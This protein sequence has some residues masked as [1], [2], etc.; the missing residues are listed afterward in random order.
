M[1]DVTLRTFPLVHESNPILNK[2]PAP[3]VFGVNPDPQRMRLLML[4]NM[5]SHHG[6]GLSANQIGMPVKVFSMRV[7]NTDNA[8]VCF[9]PKITKESDET[10]MMKEGCLSYPELYLNIKRPQFIEAT[11][12]NADGD[13][14]NVHFEGLAAR[15]F[16]HEMD[17]MKG[18]TF[19]DKVSKVFLQSARRKQKKLLRKMNVK[20]INQ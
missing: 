4:E 13:E 7:D 11:Y 12:Q 10:V 2:E 1:T 9:N 17:H 19:L 18:N 6:L 16:H 5:V 14:I 15:I 20:K 8:I 3:W